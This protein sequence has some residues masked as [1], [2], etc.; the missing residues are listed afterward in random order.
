M[1]VTTDRSAGTR[2]GAD[3]R[4]VSVRGVAERWSLVLAFVGAFV[5][6]MVA[7]PYH[8]LASEATLI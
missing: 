7:L 6:F 1:T 2:R 4:R 8:H 3:L 5:F